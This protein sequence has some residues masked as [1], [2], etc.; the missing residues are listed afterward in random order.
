MS[1]RVCVC[2]S[3]R[4]RVREYGEEQRFVERYLKLRHRSENNE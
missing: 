4:M 2:V 1:E 3:E